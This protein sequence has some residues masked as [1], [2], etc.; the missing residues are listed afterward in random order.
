MSKL[1]VRVL[2]GLI[3]DLDHEVDRALLIDWGDRS[4]WLARWLAVR[5]VPHQDMLG[6]SR[7]KDP[8]LLREGEGQQHGIG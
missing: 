7:S 3:V 5:L 1:L 6:D 4:V 8:V 2:F